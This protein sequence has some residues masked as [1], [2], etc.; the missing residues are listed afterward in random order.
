[1]TLYR[2]LRMQIWLQLSKLSTG[3]ATESFLASK[4]SR[5][6]GAT[7]TS[8]RCW[9][10]HRSSGKKTEADRFEAVFQA[11]DVDDSKAID[12]TEFSRLFMTLRSATT[13]PGR[14]LEEEVQPQRWQ[15]LEG[16]L[17]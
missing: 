10:C 13:Q 14:A 12:P 2:Q 5:L 9:D 1:M 7:R 15:S 16:P 17:A 3:I 8:A 4:S 11:I 6:A